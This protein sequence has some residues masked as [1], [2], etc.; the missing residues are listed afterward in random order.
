MIGYTKEW[1]D[2]CYGV[3]PDR[4][5]EK[6]IQSFS[7]FSIQTD[8]GEWIIDEEQ[9][10]KLKVDYVISAFGSELSESDGTLYMYN[11]VQN[12]I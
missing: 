7:I 4:A 9:V 12:T 11:C 6:K 1:E 8:S 5:G 10:V 2:C 3:L